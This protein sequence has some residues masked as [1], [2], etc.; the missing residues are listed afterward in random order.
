M[1]IYTKKF[2]DEEEKNSIKNRNIYTN[3]IELDDSIESI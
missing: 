2:I 1:D 3:S